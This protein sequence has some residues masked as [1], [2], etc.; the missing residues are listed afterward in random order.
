MDYRRF[1]DLLQETVDLFNIKVAAFCLMPNHYHLMVRTPDAN[2]SRCMRH[3]NGVYTQ[4]YNI[5]Y[6][7]DGTLFRGRFKS[8]LVEADSYVLQLVR[9]IHLNPVKAGL[10]KSMDQYVWSSH[11]GYISKA[12]KWKWLYRSFV[13]ELLTEQ[14]SHQIKAYKQYM[15]QK[16]DQDFVRNLD[17]KKQP[18]MLG[19]ETFISWIK[20]Q[21]FSQKTDKEV[22]ASKEL[23]PDLETIIDEISRFYELNPTAL[24]AVRRGIKNEPRDVAI[25]LIRF[26]RSEPLMNIGKNFGLNR[27]SSVSSAVNRVKKRLMKD[28]RFKDRIARIHDNIFKGQTKT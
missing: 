11:K 24:K 5:R 25:Y 16:Q 3:I 23:A 17:R 7:R 4:R 27:Y 6:G 1:I 19:S 15:N 13:L 20:D 21:F 2:L 14:K 28:R 10:V 9:Y 18:S 12:S 8:I 26:M 22:P